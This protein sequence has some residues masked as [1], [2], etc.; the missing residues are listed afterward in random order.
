MAETVRFLVRW[1]GR[2]AYA[3]A[4]ALTAALAAYFS[5]NLSVTSGVT[6]V[7]ELMALAETEAAD[8]LRD[9]GLVMRRSEAVDAY[10]E[11]VETGR[12]R[13]QVPGPRT[14]VKRGSTVTIGI[15]LG[16][17]VIVVPDLSGQTPQ[18]AQLSLSTANLKLGRQLSVFSDHAG[19]GTVAGQHPQPGTPASPDTVVD[20]LVANERSGETYVMPDLVYRPYDQIRGFFDQRGFRL[21]NV[22]LETYEG[23]PEG[24][25]LRQFPLAGHPLDRQDLI[26]LVVSTSAQNGHTE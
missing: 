20:L 14:L 8:L 17:Q 21:G 23:I 24:V 19:S 2:F 1:L 3:G 5:F 18:T 10:D 15:S 26:S 16:P 12:V 7:P 11:T 25:I 13:N 6:T 22:K 9:H 4:L